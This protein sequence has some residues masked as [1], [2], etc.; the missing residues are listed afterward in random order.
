MDVENALGFLLLVD[1]AE[2][3]VVAIGGL[4]CLVVGEEFGEAC[5]ELGDGQCR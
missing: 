5:L 2:E 3:E 1:L 4:D